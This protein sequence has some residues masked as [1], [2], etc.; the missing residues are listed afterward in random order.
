MAR[1]H[2]MGPS[3]QKVPGASSSFPSESLHGRAGV[4][5]DFFQFTLSPLAT[6]PDSH[7]RWIRRR[8]K[9]FSLLVQISNGFFSE[10]LTDCGPAGPRQVGHRAGLVLARPLARPSA[11][12]YHHKHDPWTSGSYRREGYRTWQDRCGRTWYVSL[13]LVTPVSIHSI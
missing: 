7:S 3:S 13:Q 8:R 11:K 12:L 2:V 10:L 4:P 6:R 5:S 1:A 9:E